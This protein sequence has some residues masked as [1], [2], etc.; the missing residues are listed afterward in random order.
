MTGGPHI[1]GGF[2]IFMEETADLSRD[3]SEKNDSVGLLMGSIM[4]I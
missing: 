4:L 2:I 3:F 1:V